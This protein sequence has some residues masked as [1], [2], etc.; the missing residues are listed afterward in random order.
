MDEDQVS[1]PGSPTCVTEEQGELS[2]R[3]IPRE[4]EF[5]QELSEK[6]NYRE[7]MRGMRLFMG[8]HQVPE[9]DT[10]SSSFDDNP[11]AAT[12]A[13]PTGNVSVKLRV[14]EWLYKKLEKLNITITEGY[15]SR[16]SETAVLLKDQFMKT[17][18]RSKGYSIYS[19]EERLFKIKDVFL[20]K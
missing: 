6:V 13:Q 4:E 14:D 3:A 12:R 20:L 17:P 2:D 10:S 11:F 1:E 9:F 19:R 8:W 7:T 18:R 5:D 15:P 16:S